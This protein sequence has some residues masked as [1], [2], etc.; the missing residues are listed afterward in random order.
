VLVC[1]AFEDSGHYLSQFF[2]NWNELVNFR[3]V[4]TCMRLCVVTNAI[5]QCSEI[6]GIFEAM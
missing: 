1:S 6:L 5:Y 3:I 2:T 4:A